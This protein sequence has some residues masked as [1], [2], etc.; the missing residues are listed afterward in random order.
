MTSGVQWTGEAIAFMRLS[1][2]LVLA[3]AASRRRTAIAASAPGATQRDTSV[4]EAAAR[5]CSATLPLRAAGLSVRC[6]VERYLPGVA[7]WCAQGHGASVIF[8]GDPA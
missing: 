6:W 4:L 5:W 8:S 3:V 2:R 1:S 7:L